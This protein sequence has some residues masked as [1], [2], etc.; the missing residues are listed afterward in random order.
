M[1]PAARAAA[2]ASFA[3]AAATS[4]VLQRLG[5]GVLDPAPAVAV[6]AQAHVPFTWRVFA[7]LLHGG[8]AGTFV[9]VLPEPWPSRLLSPLA[10]LV[11]AVALALAV[12]ALWKP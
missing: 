12:A 4:Y 9:L 11:P 10:R 7:A 3:L 2:A 8:I 6:F 5:A 1:S